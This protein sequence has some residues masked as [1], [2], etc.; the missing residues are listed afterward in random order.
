MTELTAA[1]YQPLARDE[2]PSARLD[3]LQAH[4]I[5]AGP[6]A[7]DLLL[8]PELFLSGYDVGEKIHQYAEPSDGPSLVRLADMAT[9]YATALAVGYPERDGQSLYNAVAV[10]GK[11]GERLL[12]YRKRVLPPG[13]EGE[14][15][16]PGRDVGVFDLS[17][18]RIAV[19]VCYD[20]EFPEFV[21][22]AALAGAE[23]I[24][25]P[26]A[27]KSKWAFV[28]RKM[29]PTRAFENGVFL[30]YA[31]HAGREGDSEYLGESVIVAPDG[32]EL[33]IAGQGE[34]I[35]FHTLN[36]QELALAR[37]TLPYLD[38]VAKKGLGVR[39]VQVPHK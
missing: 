10:V 1:I 24:L 27:L 8:C 39:P 26:T 17:G 31:N 18:C 2:I 9:R 34:E 11:S 25:A 14:T 3:R 30:L 35:I 22:E 12:D 4:L 28:A 7:F 21:R 33:S 20:V 32:S 15:F 6:S 36:E 13:Y 5:D 23:I 37:Q 16:Q 38:V 29:I 19:L